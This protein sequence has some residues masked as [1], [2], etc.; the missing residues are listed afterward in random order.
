MNLQTW[1]VALGIIVVVLAGVLFFGGYIGPSTAPPAQTETAIVVLPETVFGFELQESL[2]Q[3]DPIFEGEQFSS[4]VA[5]AP[6][7]GS[8]FENV[9][10][11][12]GIMLYHFDNAAH[13]EPALAILS[14]GNPLERVIFLG[15]TLLKYVDEKSAQVTLFL[16]ADNSLVQILAVGPSDGDIFAVGNAA[17]QMVNG[18]LQAQP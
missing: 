13:V 4:L 17:L 6:S 11:R 15:H 9:V 3:V 1:A 12:V 5:F 18:I 7:D 14:L 16:S 10:L 8:P 2:P